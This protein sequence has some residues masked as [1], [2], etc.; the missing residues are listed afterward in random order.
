MS[1]HRILETSESA[2]R[3]VLKGLVA[4]LFIVMVVLIFA[5][6]FTRFLTT[7]SLTWSEELSRFV[8]I[9]L[10]YL[11]SILAYAD[12]AHIAVDALLVTLRGR[13]EA[14]VQVLNRICVLAF[15]CIVVA[16]AVEFMPTT[17]MQEAPATGITM[18]YV[19]TI[20][21]LSMIFMGVVCIRQIVQIVAG[22]PGAANGKGEKA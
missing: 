16:G 18:A 2:I 13:L 14:G 5:Q 19:Y 15:V 17:L 7:S 4:L 6:V 8:M 12:N 10:I 21:P 11:A 1:I 3:T 20:I 22:R 9:W